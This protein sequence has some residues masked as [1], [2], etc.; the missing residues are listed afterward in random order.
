MRKASKHKKSMSSESV[1][2]TN[3]EATA[4]KAYAVRLGYWSDPYIKL[5]CPIPSSSTPEISRG[6]YVRVQTFEAVVIRFIQEC[7]KVCQVV[8]LGAG[9]DTLFFRL[10]DKDLLPKAYIE[11]DLPGNVRKKI[12]TLQRNKALQAAL[13]TGD[14]GFLP[15]TAPKDRI[16][17]GCYHLLSFDLKAPSASL[18]SLLCDSPDGPSLSPGL[19]TLFLAEC[20]LVYIPTEFSSSLLSTLSNKFT[21]AAFLNYEQVN[22]QDKFGEIM[23]SHFRDRSCELPGLAA[24]GSLEEQKSRF[25]NNGWTEVHAWTI[26]EVFSSFPQGAISR[27]SQLEMLDDTEITQQLYDHYCIVLATNTGAICHWDSLK[28][29]LSDLK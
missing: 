29:A 13:P 19:P 15:S 21:Q 14:S 11:L 10:K 27:I 23:Q 20:V 17:F 4:T 25:I 12:F 3:D 9:S 2:Y 24:C 26:N 18:I 28:M 16:S 7:N 8:N 6:Y 5:F 1:Q 22:M